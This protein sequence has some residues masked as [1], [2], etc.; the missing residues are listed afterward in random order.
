MNKYG[1]VLHYLRRDSSRPSIVGSHVASK[2]KIISIKSIKSL[3]RY[4]GGP[5]N[6]ID[7]FLTLYIDC[8]GF[9]THTIPV[10]YN[11][12]FFLFK[13]NSVQILH[14]PII[15]NDMPPKGRYYRVG[16]EDHGILFRIQ[17]IK[18]STILS[19]LNL[20]K[21][22]NQ[23]LHFVLACLQGMSVHTIRIDTNNQKFIRK[24]IPVPIYRF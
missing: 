20:R 10:P 18:L 3:P 14:V 22:L 17:N 9:D 12:K 16:I 19:G 4:Q 2:L 15:G 7:C 1:A 13:K 23:H 11:F 21:L 6:R 24:Y 5:T 8:A